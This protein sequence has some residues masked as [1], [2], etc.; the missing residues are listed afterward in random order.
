MVCF[1]MVTS[2]VTLV[3]GCREL[4]PLNAA[5]VPC[6]DMLMWYPNATRSN[7]PIHIQI[8]KAS[9]KCAVDRVK[10]DQNMCHLAMTRWKVEVGI[11][12]LEFE[13]A[14]QGSGSG[15]GS[16]GISRSESVGSS[17]ICFSFCRV[18]GAMPQS[19]SQV[20]VSL[21]MSWRT[22]GMVNTVQMP[23]QTNGTPQPRGPRLVN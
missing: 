5:S 7:E 6:L 19:S 14:S 22:Q 11:Y 10:P 3:S 15:T 12:T 8:S 21:C 1:I 16:F 13:S 20:T 4:S 17:C 23:I 2:Y 18:P 9:C